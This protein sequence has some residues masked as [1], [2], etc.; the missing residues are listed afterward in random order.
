MLRKISDIKEM[1]DVAKNSYQTK[2]LSVK[3]PKDCDYY[4]LDTLGFN[5][6]ILVED[7]QKDIR[8][9]EDYSI[10]INQV[11]KGQIITNYLLQN[12]IINESDI[13]LCLIGQL[14]Y[15][16][17]Q[18]LS[19]IRTF[20]NNNKKLYI[21]H[22][23]IHLNDEES[24]KKYINDILLKSFPIK[25]IFQPSGKLTIDFVSIIKS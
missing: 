16:E 19:K 9:D 5:A 15:S 4:L 17:Q 14:T 20:C 13:L 24:V 6:P 12:F 25:S 3:Y 2:G 22:N 11:T 21:I 10:K 1:E 8:N 23:L 7:L 18:F